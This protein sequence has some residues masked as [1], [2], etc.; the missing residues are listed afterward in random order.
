MQKIINNIVQE[1]HL[2]KKEIG[3]L[4]G[5]NKAYKYLKIYIEKNTEKEIEV[6]IL[7]CALGIPEVKTLYHWNS[8]RSQ[9]FKK[10]QKLILDWC[11]YA[12]LVKKE[13]KFMLED[14]E[15]MIDVFSGMKKRNLFGDC[16]YQDVARIMLCLFDIPSMKEDS[17]CVKLKDSDGYLFTEIFDNYM[18]KYPQKNN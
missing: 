3:K 18:N 12:D 17:L 9:F 15:F 14:K 7:A 2:L 16:S 10:N 6:M 4:S 8:L 1:I 5:R 13:E 11:E